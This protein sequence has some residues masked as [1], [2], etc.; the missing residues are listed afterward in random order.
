[1]SVKRKG[2]TPYRKYKRATKRSRQET[3]QIRKER[4][5]TEINSLHNGGKKEAD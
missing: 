1:M 5:G 3:K 2:K 4:E